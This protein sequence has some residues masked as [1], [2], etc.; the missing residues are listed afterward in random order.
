MMNSPQRRW[1]CRREFQYQRCQLYILF[2]FWTLSYVGKYLQELLVPDFSLQYIRQ[3]TVNMRLVYEM[4]EF[5]FSVV[6]INRSLWLFFAWT[7]FQTPHNMRPLTAVYKAVCASFIITQSIS[8]P[9]K[10]LQHNWAENIQ[11]LNIHTGILSRF[12]AI[13]PPHI[14]F[15]THLIWGP[16][17]RRHLMVLE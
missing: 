10:K 5:L 7:I 16:E 9:G 4:S 3:P 12:K 11:L 6:H 14:S 17:N 13:H 1:D 8:K 15:I 2:T